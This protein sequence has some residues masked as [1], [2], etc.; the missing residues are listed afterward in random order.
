MQ[1]PQGLPPVFQSQTLR[2]CLA[3]TEDSYLSL[4][5]SASFYSYPPWSC[6]AFKSEIIQ[7]QCISLKWWNPRVGIDRRVGAVIS[8]RGP[9][10]WMLTVTQRK[11]PFLSVWLAQLL[12]HPKATFPDSKFPCDLGKIDAAFAFCMPGVS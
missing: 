11:P 12:I 3:G 9:L 5:G 10:S 2:L 6:R 8:G 7:P 4:V 1:P